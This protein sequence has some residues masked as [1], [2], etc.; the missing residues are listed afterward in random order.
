MRVAV[1]EV[2]KELSFIAADEVWVQVCAN[3]QAPWTEIQ[4]F[5]REYHPGVLE[6]CNPNPVECFEA[7]FGEDDPYEF[8][9]WYI[10]EKVR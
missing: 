7:E 5:L 3:R 2:P 10:L 6:Q 9:D 8:E 1:T 4:D